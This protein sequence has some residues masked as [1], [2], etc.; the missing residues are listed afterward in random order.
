MFH[1]PTSLDVF[2]IKMKNDFMWHVSTLHNALQDNIL[3][4]MK[5]CDKKQVEI[6]MVNAVCGTREVVQGKSN[7][8]VVK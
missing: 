1:I 2:Y 3:F 6:L 8:D 5:N 7:R 4:C